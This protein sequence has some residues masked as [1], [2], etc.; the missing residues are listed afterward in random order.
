VAA[1]LAVFA[2]GIPPAS[3]ARTG[4]PTI[5]PDPIYRLRITV[6]T[7][8]SEAVIRLARP[9]LLIRAEVR[10][11]RGEAD[12]GSF[13]RGPL[14][15]SPGAGATS[16]RATFVTAL[17]P[18]G[19]RR[20]RFVS[21]QRGLGATRVAVANANRSPA[22]LLDVVVLDEPSRRLVSV[23]TRAVAARGP[24]PGTEPL[25][26]TVLAFYY[27][28]YRP[29]DWSGGKPI[30]DDNRIAEPYDSGDPKTL[31]RH[32]AQAR[33]ADLDGFVVSWWG[34]DA[35][36]EPA[37]T[38]LADRLP[39]DLRFALYVELFGAA[40]RTEADLVRELDYVLDTY[41]GS[42]RYLRIDGRPVVYAFSTHNVLMAHGAGHHQDY[43]G[44]WR[45]VRDALATEGH[46]PLLIGEGRPFATSDF[47]VFDGMHV[48]GT[49]DPARTTDLNR[50][51]ALTARAWAAIHGGPR[52]IWAASVLPGYDDRHIP[53]RRPDHFPREE[54]RLYEDQW[55]AAIASHADQVLVVSFNEWMETTNIEPNLAWGTRYLELTTELADRF[56]TS[57]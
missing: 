50:E 55:T 57:R 25:P 3:P 20:I 4:S 56:R 9:A 51:M 32:V 40:F 53:R 41:A 23:P 42:P 6:T 38:A 14:R 47:E 21:G 13:G 43:E 22:R 1:V 27:P 45:R 33:E 8:A 2:A 54:G 19:A 34:R 11:E 46:D 16:A 48:Y 5:P 24:V 17:T 10:R 30:A 52:R 28:W 12:W 31:N 7:T 15:L 26:P 18:A 44:V 35:A 37:V 39:A 49:Q 29:S 36:Y